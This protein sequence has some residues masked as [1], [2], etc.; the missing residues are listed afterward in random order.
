MYLRFPDS[1]DVG[2]CNTFVELKVQVSSKKAPKC[3]KRPQEFIVLD[4]TEAFLN[5]CAYFV[6]SMVFECPKVWWNL[7][8]QESVILESLTGMKGFTHIL[9]GKLIG[10]YAPTSQT[11]WSF[12][13]TTCLAPS[14]NKVLT[15]YRL[16]E[17]WELVHGEEM[18]RSEPLR[19]LELI[20]S[21]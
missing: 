17:N 5:I 9:K 20:R 10:P 1:L 13:P 4:T 18:N 15:F 6:H 14:L 2:D 21:Y 16:Y 3:F 8:R 7:I 19:Y 11:W 12:H